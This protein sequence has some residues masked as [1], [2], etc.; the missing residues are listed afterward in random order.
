MTKIFDIYDLQTLD[1]FAR[2]EGYSGLGDYLPILR[3]WD[4]SIDTAAIL[5]RKGI[6]FSEYRANPSLLEEELPENVVHIDDLYRAEAGRIAELKRQ[7]IEERV[8]ISEI[9]K[10]PFQR[11]EHPLR[12]FTYTLLAGAIAASTLIGLSKIQADPLQ[13]ESE[14]LNDPLCTSIEGL[15]VCLDKSEQGPFFGSYWE[16]KTLR[17]E[18]NKSPL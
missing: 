2:R 7:N 8:S 12:T 1:R 13:L 11:R 17:E 10:T 16:Y 9:K 18:L 14:L 15:Y 5:V 4:L 3:N 6:S